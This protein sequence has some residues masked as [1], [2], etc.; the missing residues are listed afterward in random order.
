[1]SNKEADVRGFINIYRKIKL[2]PVYKDSKAIHLFLHCLLSAQF[3]D[4]KGDVGTFVTTSQEIADELGWNTRN[5][6][7][8]FM[9]ILKNYDL[10]DYKTSN[11]NTTIYVKNFSKYQFTK[12]KK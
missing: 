11:K 1:M 4:T 10:I 7:Y 8:K 3:T 2:N 6:V 5:T 12:Q 9:K